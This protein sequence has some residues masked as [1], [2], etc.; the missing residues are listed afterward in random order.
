MF[1]L[2]ML[3]TLRSFPYMSFFLFCFRLS[4]PKTFFFEPEETFTPH[5]FC[6]FY[7]H[8]FLSPFTA[9]VHHNGARRSGCP[10][11]KS[12]AANLSGA[13]VE[14][15]G[16]ACLFGMMSNVVVWSYSYLLVQR[17]APFCSTG[18]IFWIKY[19]VGQTAFFSRPQLGCC[20]ISRKKTVLKGSSF[21]FEYK[22][23]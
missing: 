23:I 10:A 12:R 15:R 8:S 7:Y 20:L 1:L 5:P 13:G 22:N 18:H 19:L 3:A 9:P 11:V 14:Q 21:W 6:F 16:P 4:T 17:S 2:Q